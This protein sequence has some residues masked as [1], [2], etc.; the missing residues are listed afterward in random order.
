MLN[1][2]FQLKPRDLFWYGP[3]AFPIKNQTKNSDSSS[4]LLSM[5]NRLVVWLIFI[6]WYDSSLWNVVSTVTHTVPSIQMSKTEYFTSNLHKFSLRT[7][8]KAATFFLCHWGWGMKDILRKFQKFFYSLPPQNQSSSDGIR[9]YVFYTITLR[10]LCL[11]IN[12]TLTWSHMA[13][14]CWVL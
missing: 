12:I 6:A 1:K 10:L 11:V 4:H 3:L 7:V 8:K 13:F 9:K 2:Y 5:S 14:Y